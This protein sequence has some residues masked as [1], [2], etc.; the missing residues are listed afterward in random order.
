MTRATGDPRFAGICVR[1]AVSELLGLEPSGLESRVGWQL[2]G[3][4]VIGC[5]SLVSPKKT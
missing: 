3:Q 4:A 5:A 1:A 2:L